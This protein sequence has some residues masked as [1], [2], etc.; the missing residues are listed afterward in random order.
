MRKHSIRCY[1]KS[2]SL[3][4]ITGFADGIA[5]LDPGYNGQVKSYSM[6]CLKYCRHIYLF[7]RCFGMLT[8]IVPFPYG[9]IWNVSVQTRWLLGCCGRKARSSLGKSATKIKA[10][11]ARGNGA[12]QSGK[13]TPN[14]A[15]WQ[16]F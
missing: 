7:V 15:I 6:Q 8:P 13:K 3:D 5:E 9:D 11:F 16:R 2:N 14:Q 12:R 1:S 4:N 10:G